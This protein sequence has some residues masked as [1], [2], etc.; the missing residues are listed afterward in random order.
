M[1]TEAGVSKGVVQMPAHL[2]GRLCKDKCRNS[3]VYMLRI[4]YSYNV[5]K[6]YASNMF[7]S[8]AETFRIIINELRCC[9]CGWVPLHAWWWWFMFTWGGRIYDGFCRFDYEVD[10]CFILYFFSDS[11]LKL[12]LL[13]I[14]FWNFKIVIKGKS[15]C[16]L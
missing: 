10:Y 5:C 15:V 4:N 12:L 8:A 16:L 3:S 11:N 2:P 6:M 7:A 14:L 1:W 13:L 9:V